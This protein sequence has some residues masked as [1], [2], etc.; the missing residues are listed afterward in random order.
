MIEM[1]VRAWDIKAKK[2]HQEMIYIDDL[3]W[4]EEQ[5][6][7]DWEGEGYNGEKYIFMKYTG[8]KDKNGKKIFG[9]DILSVKFSADASTYEGKRTYIYSN[10]VVAY[11]DHLT[12]FVVYDPNKYKTP[13][14]L[15]NYGQLF[16]V[17]DI[18]KQSEVI[19]NKY[20]NPELFEVKR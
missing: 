2:E 19:G 18:N 13:Q 20:K 12:A 17:G 15:S 3:Y 11:A 14:P 16:K 4:F 1:E 7:H 10:Y 5:G 6:I 9:G 8:R